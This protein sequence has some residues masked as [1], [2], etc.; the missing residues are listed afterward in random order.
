MHKPKALRL[1]STPGTDSTVRFL[2]TSIRVPTM[3]RTMLY[4]IRQL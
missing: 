1:A 3:L 4:K 2:V